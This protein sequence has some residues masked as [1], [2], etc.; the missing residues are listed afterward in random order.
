[1]IAQ[2]QLTVQEITV[3]WV[4]GACGYPMG[5]P[6]LARFSSMQATEI[7]PALWLLA[8]ANLIDIDDTAMIWLSDTGE[9]AAEAI[10]AAEYERQ[11]G[12]I[13]G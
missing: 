11:M 4:L 12:A 3:L 8:R 5:K 7:D 1:M 13:H 6:R 2:V 9:V 10:L